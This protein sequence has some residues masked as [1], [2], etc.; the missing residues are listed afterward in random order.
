MVIASL[1]DTISTY[2]RFNSNDLL[3]D[4][5]EP[6]LVIAS[7]Q[8]KLGSVLSSTALPTT[9]KCK[10]ELLQYDRS[11]GGSPG[12]QEMESERNSLTAKENI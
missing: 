7:E 8:N 5:S 1:L 4:G 2:E 6:L 3:S 11:Q 12:T 9:F 10:S